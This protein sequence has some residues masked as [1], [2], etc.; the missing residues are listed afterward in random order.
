PGDAGAGP[1]VLLLSAQCSLSMDSGTPC[2]QYVQRWYYDKAVGACSPFWYGGCSGNS[3]RFKTEFECINT[4]IL[5]SK[6]SVSHRHHSIR[7]NQCYYLDMTTGLN[8]FPKRN[9]Y[10]KY[11][12]QKGTYLLKWFYDTQQNECARFW[13]GGCKGNGNRFDS[14]EECEDR[15]VTL[16][17]TDHIC[18]VSFHLLQ[19]WIYGDIWSAFLI[20]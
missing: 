18:P 5:T 8:G 7:D 2:G 6:S 9:Y 19:S 16:Q 4:C 17:T 3:N 15:C 14:Q 20:S 10:I 1:H 12:V 11:L 13:Y